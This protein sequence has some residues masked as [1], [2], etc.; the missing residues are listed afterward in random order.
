MTEGRC[1]LRKVHGSHSGNLDDQLRISD[2]A[3]GTRPFQVER[4]GL[5]TEAGAF[6][7][8]DSNISSHPVQKDPFPAGQDL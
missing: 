6:G 2:P 5:E 4:R 8:A 7:H 3:I 1:E